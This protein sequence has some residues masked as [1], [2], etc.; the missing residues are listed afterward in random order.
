MTFLR[1][2]I[3]SLWSVS[4]TNVGGRSRAAELQN[5]GLHTVRHSGENQI[6]ARVTVQCEVSKNVS[7]FSCS[8]PVMFYISV[9][10][11]QLL[12]H[13]MDEVPHVC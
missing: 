7:C 6:T 11:E 5:T 9:M 8:K 4:S 2:S 1:C 10:T 12:K 3:R 13:M